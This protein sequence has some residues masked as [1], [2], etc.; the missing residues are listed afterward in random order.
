MSRQQFSM[1]V[2]I[3]A[4]SFSLFQDLFKIF[5][6][7]FGHFSL[8]RFGLNHGCYFGCGSLFG[9]E[10]EFGCGENK[11]AKYFTSRERGKVKDKYT[12][13]KVFWDCIQRQINRG[14]SFNVTIDRIY[15]VYG[16]EKSVTR[17]INEMRK[18]KKDNNLH[19]SLR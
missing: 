7:L 12:R 17:I 10:Y 9:G 5:S 2:H 11:A 19:V 14:I 3:N 13:R 18:D 4:F 15:Q 16:Q 1:C 6:S 8:L